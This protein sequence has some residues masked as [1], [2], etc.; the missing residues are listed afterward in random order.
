MKSASNE[1]ESSLET[2]FAD[3][4]PEFRVLILYGDAT[5]KNEAIRLYQHLTERIP[6]VCQPETFCWDL[7]HPKDMEATVEAVA[8]ADMIFVAG[9]DNS[10]LP[11][12]LQ[13]ALVIGLSMRRV[14][15]G[16]LVA[17]LGRANVEDRTPSALH[18]YLEETARGTGLDFFPGVFELIEK[19]PACTIESIHER[20]ERTTLTLAGILH[21]H[22]APFGYGINIGQPD[23]KL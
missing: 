21:R 23:S 18:A 20:A 11:G 13:N 9:R 16:A 22:V 6:I 17:L 10:E 5:A 8:M 14:G 3:I 15:R 4:R 1:L 7:K 19:E 2:R 12:E